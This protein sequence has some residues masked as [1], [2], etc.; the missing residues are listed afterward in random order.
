MK[1]ILI[2]WMAALSALLCACSTQT[3]VGDGGRRLRANKRPARPMRSASHCR[4]MQPRRSLLSAVRRQIYTQPGGGYEIT[5]EI[6]DA[7]P[8]AA[9]VRRLSGFDAS[10]LHVYKSGGKE[11]PVWQFAWYAASDEGGRM[12]RCKVISDGAYCY[13]LTVSVPE[14]A[15]TAYDSMAD[16]GVLKH[17]IAA[18]VSI[19][20]KVLY[21]EKF[22]LTFAALAVIIHTSLRDAA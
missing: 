8:A 3:V 17:G 16:R 4:R 22:F 7:A 5:T 15:G 11:R 14:G 9:I 1:R 21:F 12:Y 2:G 6:L 20:E 13:A 18:G 19:N 10:A